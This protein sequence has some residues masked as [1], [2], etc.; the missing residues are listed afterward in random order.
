[1]GEQV[2]SEHKSEQDFNNTDLIRLFELEYL[3]LIG[4]RNSKIIEDDEIFRSTEYYHDPENRA[5]CLSCQ[6]R[7]NTVCLPSTS[8]QRPNYHHTT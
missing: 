4:H 7:G 5:E 8:S 3:L 6:L 2:L 1:M